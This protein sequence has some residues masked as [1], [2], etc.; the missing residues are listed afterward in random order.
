MQFKCLIGILVK[1]ISLPSWQNTFQD[2]WSRSTEWIIHVKHSDL[3]HTVSLTFMHLVLI[4]KFSLPLGL[5][6]LRIFPWSSANVWRQMWYPF[7][8]QQNNVF[9]LCFSAERRNFC[10]LKVS[11]VSAYNLKLKSKQTSLAHDLNFSLQPLSHFLILFG[12]GWSGET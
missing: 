9:F 12:S 11:N 6:F 5:D 1:I 4:K 7:H 8:H 2:D 3:H 10:S